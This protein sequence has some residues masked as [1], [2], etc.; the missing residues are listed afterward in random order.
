MPT[1]KK[2]L[3]STISA[4][5]KYTIVEV[6][7]RLWFGKKNYKVQKGKVHLKKKC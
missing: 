4:D 3:L 6:R 7:E 1:F 2:F 5:G